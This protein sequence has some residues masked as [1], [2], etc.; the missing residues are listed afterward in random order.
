MD[1]YQHDSVTTFRFVLRGELTG[2]SVQTVE[3]AWKTAKSILNRKEFVVDISGI[4]RVDLSG[5]DLL[6]RMRESGASFLGALPSNSARL[7]C[8]MDIP[9]AAPAPQRHGRRYLQMFRIGRV[10]N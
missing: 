10:S 5:I 1:I 3:Q 7:F 9:V 6:S 2:R 4:T 8:S